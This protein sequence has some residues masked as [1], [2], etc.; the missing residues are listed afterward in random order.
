MAYPSPIVFNL[1]TGIT[2]TIEGGLL[3]AVS[4][5]GATTTRHDVNLKAATHVASTFGA[6]GTWHIQIYDGTDTVFDQSAVPRED[7]EALREAITHVMG[8]GQPDTITDRWAG[9]P[10]GPQ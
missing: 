2:A 4:V 1:G 6:T 8:G 9:P 5:S 3:R 10:V 7:A